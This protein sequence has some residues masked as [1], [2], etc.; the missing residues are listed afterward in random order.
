MAHEQVIERE[1][2]FQTHEVEPMV[3]DRLINRN[4]L[5]KLFTNTGAVGTVTLTAPQDA[6]GGEVVILAAT[7]AQEFRFQPGAA[8][9]VYVNGAKQADNKFVAINTVGESLHLVHDGN[10]DWFVIALEGTATVEA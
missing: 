3:L 10:G 8:G 7:V 9:A 1:Q 2:S 6:R 5:S 4:E